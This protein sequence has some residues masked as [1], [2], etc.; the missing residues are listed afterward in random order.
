MGTGN[1]AGFLATLK[2][3]LT[4]ANQ[5]A[6]LLFLIGLLLVLLRQWQLW[7]R[8]KRR[9]AEIKATPPLPPLETWPRLPQVSALVA[10][11]NEAGNIQAHIESFLALRYP[12]KQLVLVAGGTDGTLELAKKY[13][14]EQVVV[15]QQIQ[16]EGKQRALRRGLEYTAGEIIYLTDADCIL[17]NQSFETVLYPLVIGQEQVVTGTSIPSQQQLANPFIF[18]QAASILYRAY[19]APKYAAG[20]FGRNCM[21]TKEAILR[22][23]GLM[24]EA[25]SGT[26]YVLAKMLT[27]AGIAIRQQSRSQVISDFPSS[28]G[29]YYLQQLR[30]MRNVAVIGKQFMAIHEVRAIW[31]NAL[32]GLGML[33]M[34]IVAAIWIP[35]L[36]AFWGELLAYGWL[37]RLRYAK[38]TSIMREVPAEVKYLMRIPGFLILDFIIWAGAI[39]QLLQ[40][41][42]RWV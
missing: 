39:P 40:K 9:L 25:P 14:G 31:I 35:V 36:W 6:A 8:D 38:F 18:N 16:G 2:Q 10:A 13:A 27:R 3:A 1:L 21:V 22:S 12:H 42:M 33:L 5:Q 37:A 23:G 15:L 34:P 32:T 41:R 4:W 17:H 19:H 24:A 26:D 11:W 30:W 20:L 7:Q 28:L 29:E